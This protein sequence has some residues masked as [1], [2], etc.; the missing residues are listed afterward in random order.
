MNGLIRFTLNNKFAVWL[1]TIIV[2]AAGIYS[3][4][5]MK[6]ETLPDI[7]TPLVTVTTVYPGATPQEV[8]DQVTKPIEQRVQNLSGVNVVGSSSF[9]NASQIQIEYRFET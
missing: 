6:M 7:T 8:A 1:M 5:N 3:G 9:Q 2:T 4:L